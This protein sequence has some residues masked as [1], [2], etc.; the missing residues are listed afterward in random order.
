MNILIGGAWPYANGTLHVGR[1]AALVPGDVLARYHRQKGDQVLY[2]S[3]SD[4]HGTPISVRAKK[5][6]I[7]PIAIATKYHQSFVHC[8]DK[9]GFSYDLYT[10]TD[11][12]YHKEEVK[13][14]IKTLYE[15]GYIYEKIIDQVYCEV[16]EQFL[17]DRYVEGKCSICG[18]TARGDQCDYCQSLLDPLDLSER[19]CKTCDHTPIV[20]PTK[21]LYFALS[22]FEEELRAYVKKNQENW[23]FNALQ[24]AERYINEGLQDR[25]ITRDLPW[26]IDVPIAGY[27]DKKIYVWIDAILG[28]FTASK[29]W[30]S[31][32]GKDFEDFW[33]AETRS[34]Y[35]HGKDNIPFHNVILPAL[36]IGLGIDGLPSH[37]IS[38][39]YITLEGRKLSTSENWA[40]WVEDLIETYHPDSIRYILL[41]NGP[42]KRDADFSCKELVNLNN[43]DLVG[44]YGNLVNRTLAFIKKS[45]RGEIRTCEVESHLMDRI[46]TLY[47]AVGVCIEKGE[48]KAA[49]KYIFEFIRATNKY[50]DEE[51]PWSTF[52]DAPDRC[53]HTLYQCTYCIANIS[54]LLN[55]FLPFSSQEVRNFLDLEDVTWQPISLK[56]TTL[57]E[58]KLLFTRLEK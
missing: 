57:P 24:T 9:L 14:I 58:L 5:E 43:A 31:T 54:N 44:A 49:L 39:E 56:E 35:V 40:I 33:N 48:F 30:A 53:Y 46:H 52:K 4:C 19:V 25:A 28:Y 51:R 11:H 1:I 37:I 17:P 8:F 41:A 36:L 20:K 3:G 23:R 16:C 38:S 42:E 2:V 6:G 7:E 47:E 55:P 15:K 50:F 34:Y 27:E 21:Q 26:G 29:K 22:K 45:F 13:D 12:S 10:R 32:H 18:Q